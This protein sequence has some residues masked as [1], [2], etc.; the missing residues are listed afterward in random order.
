M[1]YKERYMY[2]KE[3]SDD[4]MKSLEDERKDLFEN[5][6]IFGKIFFGFLFGFL[7]VFSAIF[8]YGMVTP[9][10]ALFFKG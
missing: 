3:V 10:T 1:N 7:F 2:Y 6:T 9:L 5:C 4:W 8:G